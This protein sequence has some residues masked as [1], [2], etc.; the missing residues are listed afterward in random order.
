VLVLF[1]LPLSLSSST[2]RAQ[3]PRDSA[4][5]APLIV[6]VR[7]SY[8][9]APQGHAT[10]P[11]ID[12]GRSHA[13]RNGAI[14]GAITGLAAGA[15]AGPFLVGTGCYTSQHSCN[16]NA[17]KA[18]LSLFFGVEAAVAGAITGAITGKVISLIR[19]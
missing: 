3:A 9:V 16:E 18:G 7:R 19:D 6:Q 13:M 1:A 11:A 12:S 10:N 2:V 17:T 14:I 5:H 8:S 4:T 15:V